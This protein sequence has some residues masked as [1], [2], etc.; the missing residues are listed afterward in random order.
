MEKGWFILILHVGI[1]IQGRKESGGN[2]RRSGGDRMRLESGGVRNAVSKKKY[3]IKEEREN[4]DERDI[5]EKNVR[6]CV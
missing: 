2:W 4:G 3:I 6:L 5:D 1:Q